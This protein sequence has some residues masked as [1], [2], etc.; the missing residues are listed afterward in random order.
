M[1]TKSAEEIEVAID[2]LLRD[3]QAVIRDGEELLRAGARDLTERGGAARERLA[4]ALEVAKDTQ[5]RLQS[6]AV[7]GAKT[8]D[9]LVRDNPYRS[10]GIAF[11]LGIFMGLL[12]KR[13]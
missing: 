12:A 6:A 11:G 9:R 3:L 2:K 8:A 10:S 5:R 13:R 1:Q 4:A 7:E